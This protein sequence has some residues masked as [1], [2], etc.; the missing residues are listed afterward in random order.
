M[1]LLGLTATAGLVLPAAVSCGNGQQETTYKVE[2][3]SDSVG[4]ESL[5][6]SEIKEKTELEVGF[7][8]KTGYNTV[9]ECDVTVD[10][11]AVARTISDDGTKVTV[12]ADL[13]TGDVVIK[14]TAIKKAG[15]I[16]NEVNENLDLAESG[17]KKLESSAVSFSEEDIKNGLEMYFWVEND[18]YL[19]TF[20]GPY[21]GEEFTINVHWELD[22]DDGDE[23][24]YAYD[25]DADEG[26]FIFWHESSQEIG[27][28]LLPGSTGAEMITSMISAGCDLELQIEFGIGALEYK[29]H[30]FDTIGQTEI[31]APGAI[32]EIDVTDI[33]GNTQKYTDKFDNV[34]INAEN[35]YDGFRIDFI[36]DSANY[37]VT[38]TVFY[39][40]PAV[41]TEAGTILWYGT[42]F[43]VNMTTDGVISYIFND[44]TTLA[45]LDLYIP[46]NIQ[47][48]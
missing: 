27:F 48:L 25:Y 26:D 16:T 13:I 35:V 41:Y 6:V 8:F 9:K 21:D 37:T 17:I 11:S 34:I 47:P 24:L 39:Q 7:N 10:G 18:K 23:S 46:F 29:M 43:V 4:V 42:D 20:T 33:G 31:L 40:Y 30:A 5:T 14:A 15:S 32:K 36:Y 28:Y 22:S 1:P 12:A 38:P 2:L 45:F 44:V 19:P 3:S